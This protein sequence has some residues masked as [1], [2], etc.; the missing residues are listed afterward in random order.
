MHRSEYLENRT[1]IVHVTRHTIATAGE[2]T[3][4]LKYATDETSYKLNDTHKG[5]PVVP[6]DK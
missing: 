6:M 4:T 1:V 5:L 2:V 3:N